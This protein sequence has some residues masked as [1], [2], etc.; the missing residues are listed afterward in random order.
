MLPSRD[1]RVWSP[2]PSS[3]LRRSLAAACALFCGAA[4]AQERGR[5]IAVRAGGDAAES[6]IEL[7]GDRPLSFTTLKLRSPPRV[8]V[9]FAETDLALPERDLPVDDG[10]IRRV[11]AAG[12]TR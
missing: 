4:V 6:A 10:T 1:V 8:V 12:S 7:V 9:D 2:P 3:L 5:L 11:A